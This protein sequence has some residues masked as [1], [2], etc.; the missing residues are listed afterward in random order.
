MSDPD[1]SV[2]GARLPRRGSL[3]WLHLLVVLTVL[4]AAVPLLVVLVGLAFPLVTGELERGTSVSA[5][6]RLIGLPDPDLLK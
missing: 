1:P 6:V 3:R 4:G 5:P 2:A